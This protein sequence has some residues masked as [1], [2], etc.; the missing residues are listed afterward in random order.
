MY[1]SFITIPIKVMKALSKTTSLSYTNLGDPQVRIP[2]V[3]RVGYAVISIYLPS[4]TMLIIGYL[5]LFFLYDNDNFE[6]RVMTALTTLLVMA[7][8]FTQVCA[9][10]NNSSR[11]TARKLQIVS[12]DCQEQL[13]DIISATYC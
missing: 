12:V 9:R 5:T 13:E 10:Y 2:L 4:L 8:L 6:V 3:R 1:S 11:L 7:T